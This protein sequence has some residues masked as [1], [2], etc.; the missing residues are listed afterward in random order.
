[1]SKTEVYSWRVDP[2][3]KSELEAVARTEKTSISSLVERA[4]REW[5]GQRKRLIADEK[6]EQER[7]NRELDKCMGNIVGDGVSA[8]N[9]VVR[10]VISAKLK[11][12]YAH[13]P[14]PR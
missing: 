3:L 5:L 4:V 1:M 9:D 11:A 14:P 10:R 2:E 13:R 6:A 8:T 7:I 12:K